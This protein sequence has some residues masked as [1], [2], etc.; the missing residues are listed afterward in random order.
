VIGVAGEAA[1]FCERAGLTILRDFGDFP[2]EAAAGEP[3]VTVYMRAPPALKAALETRAK[4]QGVSLNVLMLRC[5]ED[6][7]K[8]K[9]QPAA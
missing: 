9:P 1:K 5:A 8:R 2:P 7:L 3:A 6:C 4:E